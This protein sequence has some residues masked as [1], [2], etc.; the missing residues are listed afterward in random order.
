[1]LIQKQF[2]ENRTNVINLKRSF[3][4]KKEDK[5]KQFIKE[6]NTIKDIEL[7]KPLYDICQKLYVE[8]QNNKLECLNYYIDYE[9]DIK[10]NEEYTILYAEIKNTWNLPLKKRY[11]MHID[12]LNKV[13]S[14]DK[15]LIYNNKSIQVNI[16]EGQTSLFS[17]LN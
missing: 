3:V 17:L 5:I 9:K 11:D 2:I 6:W 13:L 4:K 1:M 10:K 12:L 8:T 16:E 7:Y 15:T 14:K